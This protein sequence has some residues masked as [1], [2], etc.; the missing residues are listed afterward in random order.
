MAI[1][2][3]IKISLD[4]PKNQLIV[5]II[6]CSISIFAIIIF[7]KIFI[8]PF[9]N[10]WYYIDDS[11]YYSMGEFFF[12]MHMA[13]FKYRILTPF[14]VYLLP[15]GTLVDF[16]IVNISALFATSILFFNYLKK[17]GFTF[18]VSLIGTL[19]YILN[20]TNIFYLWAIC[21][22]DLVFIF[23]FLLSFYAVLI[24]NNKLFIISTSLG[25]LNKEVML[26]CLLFFFFHEIKKKDFL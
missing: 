18:G 9:M 7:G 6:I 19:I 8:H 1:D 21:Y 20:P 3:K 13:P 22:V 10:G 17:L 26:L 16:M 2:K 23:F 4:N 15:F 14:L 11:D 5:T 25:I 24:E 12:A